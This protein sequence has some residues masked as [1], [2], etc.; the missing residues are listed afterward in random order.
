MTGL[1]RMGCFCHGTFPPDMAALCVRMLY[2][3]GV[4][5]GDTVGAGFSGSFPG[6]VPT[7]L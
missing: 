6:M 5:P 4:R 1:L 2:E 7:I 3:A